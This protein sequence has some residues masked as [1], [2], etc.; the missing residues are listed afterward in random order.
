VNRGLA[1]TNV[2][3]AK[4]EQ[5]STETLAKFRD[6]LLSELAQ[7]PVVPG[8]VQVEG[9]D[10]SIKAVEDVRAELTVL[11]DHAKTTDQARWVVVLEHALVYLAYLIDI[12][13]ESTDD[14]DTG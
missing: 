6:A 5:L 11:R 12:A 1:N 10:Y 14:N 3:F 7:V 13:K 2:I 4:T 8:Y 9:V